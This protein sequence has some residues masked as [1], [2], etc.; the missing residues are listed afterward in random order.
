M[1]SIIIPVYNAQDFIND[2]LDSVIGQDYP[3]SEIE[4]ILIDDGSTDE[5]T[6]ILDEFCRRTN[7][8]KGR[9][10]GKCRVIHQEN[11]G[12]ARTRTRG[13]QEAQGDCVFV[14]SHDC[15]A[16]YD[17]V[18]SVVE[19]FRSD[20]GV[21]IVQ[22][23]ILPEREIGIPVFHCTTVRQ[24]SF[25]Y[26]TAAIAYRTSALDQAGR[27]FDQELSEFGDDTDL[28]WR[29]LEV[30]FKS[31][32]LDKPTAYHKVLPQPFFK[33]VRKAWGIQKFPLLVKKHPGLK[34]HLSLGFFWGGWLRPLRITLLVSALVVLLLKS[35]PITIFLLVTVYFL[36]LVSTLK[37]T[38]LFEIS[39]GQKL[40]IVLPHR[41]LT[42]VVG[43]VALIWG[44]VRNQVA[45]F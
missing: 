37:E 27:F 28:A 13:L 18:S 4:F 25:S 8:D 24:K 44:S 45:V 19:I 7:I 23:Q 31:F 41:F 39:D 34:E 30:G 12:P 40:L 2:C 38:A 6:E 10:R 35:W 17:W 26:E 16:S 15:V 1:V 21:G 9:A 5:S 29:I 20:Q 33:E 11:R 42:E 14:L 32:W 22:G 36:L 43:S 3:L